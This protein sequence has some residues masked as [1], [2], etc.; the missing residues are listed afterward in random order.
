MWISYQLPYHYPIE[1][2]SYFTDIPI[3]FPLRYYI[4]VVAGR[5]LNPSA[6]LYDVNRLHSI[7]YTAGFSTIHPKDPCII[8]QN[9]RGSPF[10]T[11]GS[12]LFKHAAIFYRQSSDN[13]R[14]RTCRLK[15]MLSVNISHGSGPI[16]LKNFHIND[17]KTVRA[18][19][20]TKKNT[21][22]KTRK[23]SKIKKSLKIY[24]FKKKIFP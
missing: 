19:R 3:I 16:G 5:T 21:K 10:H 1:Y 9:M 17:H 2:K 22:N 23:H 7:V 13:Y 18:I 24:E 8:K 6:R 15:G 20:K 11:K 4:L 12:F 14:L